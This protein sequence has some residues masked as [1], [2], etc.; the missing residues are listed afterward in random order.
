M[1]R[2]ILIRVP[3]FKCYFNKLVL[4]PQVNSTA[5]GL[6]LLPLAVFFADTVH[7]Q[8][9]VVTPS[10][11]LGQEYDDNFRLSTDSPTE[12]VYTTVLSGAVEVS[13]L[14]EIWQLRAFGQYDAIHYEGDDDD[15]AD[16][17][18][19]FAGFSSIYET[20]RGELALEGSYRRDSILRT[21]N[22]DIDPGGVIIDPADDIDIDLVQRQVRRERFVIGPAWRRNLTELTELELAYEFQDTSYDDPEGL[23]LIDFYEHSG[24]VELT[25]Q[26]TP[27]TSISTTVGADF[28]RGDEEREYDNYSLAG[29]AEHEFSQ[30]T[31][32]GAGVGIRYTSFDTPNEDGDEIG[33]I[34]FIFGER[35]TQLARYFLRY[36]KQLLP[37][38]AGELI[39][40]DIVT[41]RVNRELRPRLDFF[42]RG[43]FFRNRSELEGSTADRYYF[44]VQPGLTWEF[45]RAWSLDASYRFDWEERDVDDDSA[46]THI[47]FVALNYIWPALGQEE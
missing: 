5:M 14:T 10:I 45:T 12:Q 47:L 25:R 42:L 9:W 36:E 3:T 7:A 20:Q 40:S 29:S 13:R 30:T 24:A 19:Q 41:L 6:C 33:A 43:R 27:L 1:G 38:G 46:N 8:A 2:L 11:S 34:G 37:S 26:L 16:K 44:S 22:F 31:R 28:Y 18:N 23:D 35:R 21:L 32:G 17:H 4:P 15:L 39:D